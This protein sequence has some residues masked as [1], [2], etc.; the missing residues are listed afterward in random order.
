MDHPLGEDLAGASCRLHA[1]GV[2]AG[3]HPVVAQFRGLAQQVPVV[4]GE[5]FGAVEEQA[6]AHVGQG[7]DALAGSLVDRGQV[8]PVFLQ[9]QERLVG[10]NAAHAVGLG[11]RFEGADHQAPG[12]LLHVDAVVGVAQHRQARRQVRDRFGHQVEVLAGVQRD[13]H[14]DVASQLVGPHAGCGDDVLG[15]DRALVG[16]HADGTAVGGADALDRDALED[17]GAP[18]P[19]HGGHGHG[20]VHGRCLTVAGQ[21][22]ATDDAFRVQERVPT[23]QVLGGD[24]LDFHAEGVGHAGT[25][26]QLLHA[27]RVVG[28]AERTHLLEPGGVAHVAF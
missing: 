22:D 8:F 25:P 12:L 15:V 14:P 6:D 13:V 9:L 1:D 10:G 18:L 2:E 26:H 24:D 23:A 27:L 19:G 16:V 28:H 17:P 21:P 5:R 7:R 4:G 20:G 3:G 11:H